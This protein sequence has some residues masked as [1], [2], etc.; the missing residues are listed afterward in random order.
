VRFDSR[1]GWRAQGLEDPAPLVGWENRAGRIMPLRG[2]L[3]CSSQRVCEGLRASQAVTAGACPASLCVGGS[4]EGAARS[5]GPIG[6]GGRRV[7]I[8][9]T[10]VGR[11][12]SGALVTIVPSL[13]MTLV[14]QCALCM[15]PFSRQSRTVNLIY[16]NLGR[17]SKAFGGEWETLLD[18]LASTHEPL[19]GAP[20]GLA[21]AEAGRRILAGAVTRMRH[22]AHPY[23]PQ[24]TRPTD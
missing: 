15:A 12:P 10:A 19:S 1:S 20:G 4:R 5:A 14:R 8:G 6:H 18:F 22:S 21:P 2:L 24:R 11:R 13:S 9:A 7:A 17:R 3:P 16:R 23:R